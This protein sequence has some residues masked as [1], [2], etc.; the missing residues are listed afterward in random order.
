VLGQSFMVALIIS[1]RHKIQPVYKMKFNSNNSIVLSIVLLLVSN[2]S[3]A[4]I[5]IC[6][7]I[8]TSLNVAKKV[9]SFL[10]DYPKLSLDDLEKFDDDLS[11]QKT[12][13]I[14]FKGKYTINGSL[15]IQPYGF[16]ITSYFESESHCILYNL[17]NGN[18]QRDEKSFCELVAEKE[19][20]DIFDVYCSKPLV[21]KILVIV[22]PI[23][24]IDYWFTTDSQLI[25]YVFDKFG[26]VQIEGKEFNIYEDDDGK[27]HFSLPIGNYAGTITETNSNGIVQTDNFAI[28]IYPSIIANKLY[29]P[30]V[31]VTNASNE[32]DFYQA[33]LIK[34]PNSETHFE[35]DHSKLIALKKLHHSVQH[36]DYDGTGVDIPKLD[37]LDK[38]ITSARLKLT[39]PNEPMQFDLIIPTIKN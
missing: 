23:D 34:S 12:V 3:Y 11:A 6:H 4:D 30:I 25:E 22:E 35:L 28:I 9:I 38:P 2:F 15:N 36:V 14:N 24:K 16:S 5:E 8:N 18:W 19:C 26:N 39:D 29:I 1:V 31:T 17:E 10:N 20:V 33:E 21:G 7:Q 13:E 37:R 32:K 27:L